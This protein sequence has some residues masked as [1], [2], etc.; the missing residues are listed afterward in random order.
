[1]GKKHTILKQKKWTMNK[2][3]TGETVLLNNAMLNLSEF[4]K[5][6]RKEGCMSKSLKIIV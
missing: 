3:R 5:T 4:A 1:M 6:R 2:N